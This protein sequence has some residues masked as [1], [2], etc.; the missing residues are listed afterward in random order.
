MVLQRLYQQLP[1]CRPLRFAEPTEDLVLDAPLCHLRP[2]QR[3]QTGV[4]DVDDVASA[5]GRIPPT[6]HELQVLEVV[7]QQ[8]NSTAQSVS[9]S[10][11]SSAGGASISFSSIRPTR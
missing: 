1:E 8:R 5:V 10:A 9:I 7:E 6:L 11:S 3:F 2:L 4:G